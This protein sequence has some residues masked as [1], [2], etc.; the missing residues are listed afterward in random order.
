M[1]TKLINMKFEGVTQVQETQGTLYCVHVYYVY[2]QCTCGIV[3][4]SPWLTCRSRWF[5]AF[6]ARK[7]A[8][9]F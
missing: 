9:R 4:Y 7:V 3:D 2:M 5:F 6:S 1:V 8:V